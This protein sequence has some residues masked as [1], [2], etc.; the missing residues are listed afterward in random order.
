M[1]IPSY[2]E[3][4]VPI[5]K[6][7]S[8]RKEHSLHLSAVLTDRFAVIKPKDWLSKLLKKMKYSFKNKG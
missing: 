4:M 5:L 6:L 8:D 7:A 1:P 2:H 3:A